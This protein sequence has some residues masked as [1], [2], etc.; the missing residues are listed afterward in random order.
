MRI[1]FLVEAEVHPMTP[2][3]SIDMVARD[4]ASHAE[5]ANFVAKVER[6]QWL[7]PHQAA[8]YFAQFNGGRTLESDLAE[9]RY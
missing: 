6:G 1:F 5:S 2:A 7:F 8:D 4:L 9:G 3:G